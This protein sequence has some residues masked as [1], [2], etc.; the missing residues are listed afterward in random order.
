MKIRSGFVSNSS[1]SSFS[2]F[3]VHSTFKELMKLFNL[4]PEQKPGCKHEYDRTIA[5]FCPECGK[6]AWITIEPDWEEIIEDAVAK[7]GWDMQSVEDVAYVGKCPGV[8]KR[9]VLEYLDE[10]KEVAIA[11][12]D[13]FQRKPEF[14]SGEYAC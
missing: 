13:F 14:H 10:L 8:G 12:E 11:L 5:K 3:G 2:I 6:K 4:Q 9:N 7:R 1:T